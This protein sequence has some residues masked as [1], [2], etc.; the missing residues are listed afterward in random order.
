M[1]ALGKIESMMQNGIS[2]IISLGVVAVL[3]LVG[4][5]SFLVLQEKQVSS[6]EKTV[7]QVE[8]V[9]NPIELTPSPEAPPVDSQTSNNQ[10][11]HAPLP[12]STPTQPATEFLTVDR[13]FTDATFPALP[14][15][16]ATQ[17]ELKIDVYP[18]VWSKNGYDGP[19][20]EF[21]T[22]CGSD[23]DML[24]TCFLWEVTKVVVIDP[25][26]KF[27]ELRK[28]FNRNAYS[29]EITRRWVLYG[30]AGAGLPTAGNYS[31]IYYKGD[32]TALTQTVNYT[33]NV[34]EAP[35]DISWRRERNDLLVA[36]RPPA[37]MT[38]AMW[39][40][41]IVFRQ[42][43]QVL[44]QTVDWNASGAVLN[45][46]PLQDGEVAD[47]NVSSYFHGGYAYP[48]NLKLIW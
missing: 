19:S 11:R 34:V 1:Q 29:D 32:A 20:Y 48:L 28:D 6:H 27:F 4:V 26:N 35:S 44:S 31:F 13:E 37:G 12:S 39:Y 17:R 8:D 23:Y 45:N 7:Q 16:S 43:G 9:I 47:M 24:E 38:S 2:Q 21:K 18:E 14:M 5:G 25:N 33:P 30:P 36:W 46:F 15:I 10:Q 41:V 3:I 40:K 22:N 42:N